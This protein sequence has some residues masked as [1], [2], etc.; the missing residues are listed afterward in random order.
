MQDYTVLRFMQDETGGNE[1]SR[2]FRRD[3]GLNSLFG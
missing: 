3:A 2:Q 1:K